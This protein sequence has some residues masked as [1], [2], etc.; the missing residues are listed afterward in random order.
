[1]ISIIPSILV[2]DKKTFLT[3]YTGLGDSVSMIQLDIADGKFVP[4]ATWADPKT[5]SDTVKTNVELHLMVNDPVAEMKKWVY[6]RQVTRVLIHVESP[7]EVAETIRKA[8]QINWEIG[9]VLNP[10]TPT[11]VLHDFLDDIDLVMFMGVYPGFQ[12]QE[13]IP[14]TCDRITQTK[15]KGIT[16]PISVDGGVNEKT[17]P[18]LVQSGVDIICPGSAVFG[19]DKTPAE[20][21]LALQQLVV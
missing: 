9:L 16:L 3:N 21:I 7:H 18:A 2:P 19:N 14:E 8:K 17:I 11:S 13:F 15:A 20:N 10:N 6:V 4:N 5:V 12:G 1:M